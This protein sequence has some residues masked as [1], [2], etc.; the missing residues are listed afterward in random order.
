MLIFGLTGQ[1]YQRKYQEDIKVQFFEHDFS[2]LDF[3]CGIS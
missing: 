1:N 2:M 3:C